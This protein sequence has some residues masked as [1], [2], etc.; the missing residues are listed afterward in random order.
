[1]NDSFFM[2]SLLIPRDKNLGNYIDMY[3]QPLIDL[4]KDL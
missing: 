3:V 4:L 2:L 1:M